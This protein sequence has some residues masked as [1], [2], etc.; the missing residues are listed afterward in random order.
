[1][2][3]LLNCHSEGNYRR[4][5]IQPLENAITKLKKGLTADP[6]NSNLYLQLGQAYCLL[7]ETQFAQEAF[8]EYEYLRPNN[9]IG[10]ISIGF[11]QFASGQK[12]KAVN[13]WGLAGLGK[14][15]FLSAGN[16]EFNNQNFLNALTYYEIANSFSELPKTELLNYTVSSI[17]LGMGIPE[18]NANIDPVY[19]L[20]KDVQLDANTL[21][22]ISAQKQ[23]I[24]GKHLGDYPFSNPKY[25]AMWWQ[26]RAVAIVN[27]PDEADF[28]L[29]IHA[30]HR[31]EMPG[32]LQIEVDYQP[33]S[34]FSVDSNWIEQTSNIHL[35]EGFHILAFHY[36][37]DN[38][39]LLLDQISLRRNEK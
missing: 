3:I 9:P 39:D 22:W 28:S 33:I 23:D 15:D 34:Q 8:K 18:L 36:L 32:T 6:K 25:G 20:S 13:E 16:D 26:G 12:T 30:I 1:M 35:T 2:E 14:Q 29:S 7:G 27:A 4:E 10:H 19:N 37:E 21:Y 24:N 11:T 17:V 5:D 38:G 31:G